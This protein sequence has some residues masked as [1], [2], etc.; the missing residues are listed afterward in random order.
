ME[1]INQLLVRIPKWIVSWI[2]VFLDATAGYIVL[3]NIQNYMTP[4]LLRGTLSATQ[5]ENWRFESRS[6]HPFRVGNYSPVLQ[7]IKSKKKF[8]I[9]GSFF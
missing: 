2:L 3:K 6:G 8:R 5:A 9:F 1:I 4:N 7:N